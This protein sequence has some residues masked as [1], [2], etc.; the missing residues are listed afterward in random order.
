MNFFLF[1]A[2]V[3]GSESVHEYLNNSTKKGKI[4]NQLHNHFSFFL[5]LKHS[6]YYFIFLD[7]VVHF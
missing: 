7:F 5:N 4:K 1:T 6:I 3:K 2:I